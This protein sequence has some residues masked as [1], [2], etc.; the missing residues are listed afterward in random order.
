MLCPWSGPRFAL[1][2]LEI[3][4]PWAST[5]TIPDERAARRF[6]EYAFEAGVRV[7]DTAPSY[8]LSEARLGD[9]L[10][11]LTGAERAE[12]FIATKFGET[13]NFERGQPDTDHSY[14]VLRRSVD[15]SLELLGRIDLLQVHKS[16]PEVL[17][18]GDLARAMEYAAGLGIPM[19]GASVKDLESARIACADPR[20][21]QLQF[22]YNAANRAM[23]TIFQQARGAGR[24][25]FLNRPLNMGALLES[26][27]SV[28]SAIAALLE[29]PFDG[30]VLFGTSSEA[31]LAEDLEA[32]AEAI[33]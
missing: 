29:Q 31:H 22:P 23:G 4:R 17:Q 30:A 1:G 19:F 28:A 18:S 21:R 14:D 20:F 5:K 26:G 24:L 8:A 33:G 6:L 32:F 7:F 9:F 27:G 16:T 13:W 2:L 25:L 15:R 3:G 11:S 10:K 12:L